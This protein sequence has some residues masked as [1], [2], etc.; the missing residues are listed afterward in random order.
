MD[1]DEKFLT[2]NDVAKIFRHS[3]PDSLHH[4]DLSAVKISAGVLEQIA[5]HSINFESL[6][7]GESTGPCD[8]A[9]SIVLN[10]SPR[11]NALTIR[12]NSW[13]TCRIFELC[14]DHELLQSI[15]IIECYRLHLDY[16]I[17]YITDNIFVS[18]I[19]VMSSSTIGDLIECLS[20]GHIRTFNI[21]Y[22][23]AELPNDFECW[24]PEL[25]RDVVRL[26]SITMQGLGG[27]NTQFNLPSFLS[28]VR[29]ITY[30]DL[31]DCYLRGQILPLNDLVHLE[32]LK[33]NSVHCLDNSFWNQKFRHL[34]TLETNSLKLFENTKC[35]IKW[36]MVKTFIEN[37][38][39]LQRLSLL[40]NRFADPKVLKRIYCLE[41][42]QSRRGQLII[43]VK[44]Q[45]LFLFKHSQAFRN[46]Q[47]INP[48]VEFEEH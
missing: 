26:K 40:N 13:F 38:P 6:V 39:S 34:K 16:L 41:K 47:T 42:C 3:S 48:F 12:N 31:S 29:W 17:F 28:H 45:I 32:T 19:K 36:L 18:N 21:I 8:A 27:E 24:S 20:D 43:V 7:I 9:L 23:R 15:I 4:V 44:R 14:P 33:I 2:V 46:R 35:T 25:T 30:L 11:L 5:G 22:N 1:F 10:N 37:C